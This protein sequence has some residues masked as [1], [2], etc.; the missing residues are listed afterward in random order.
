M[1]ILNTKQWMYPITPTGEASFL[2][3]M[4]EPSHR[5]SGDMTIISWEADPD[6][7]RAYT[8]EQLEVDG[9]GQMTLWNFEGW[10]YTDKMA[11]EFV[12]E[13][14]V[15]YA[16]SYFMVPCR[17]EGLDYYFMLYSWVNRDWLAYLGRHGGMPHKVADVQFSHF[18]EADVLHNRPQPGVRTTVTVEN[19][20]L[21][22]RASV[23]MEREY[24]VEELPFFYRPDVPARHV[25]HR[26][27]WDICNSRPMVDDLVAH[28][29]DDR[30]IGPVWGGPATLTFHDAENE[31]V[32]PFKPRVVHGGWR[33]TLK[34]NHSTSPPVVLHNYLAN[35]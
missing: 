14:R 18:H 10:H 4:Q 12:S 35:E 8:P 25:G 2:R 1:A 34:F 19:V 5:I 28:W 15:Q 31:E 17:F 6:V 27:F 16:E 3:L 32:L 33:W 11:T 26:Q 22:L 9:S 20:G 24:T 29:G 13:K 7:V 23:E 21:V 30:E